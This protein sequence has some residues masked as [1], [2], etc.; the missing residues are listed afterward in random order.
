MPMGAGP[1]NPAP[2]FLEENIQMQMLDCE[3]RIDNEPSQLR[4]F[5]TC[6]LVAVDFPDG[7]TLGDYVRQAERGTFL[8]LTESLTEPDG[9]HV[10]VLRNGQLEFANA[11]ILKTK[12][13][14][15]H[16]AFTSIN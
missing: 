13:L 16:Q 14:A 10:S 4:E 12:L 15:V 7:L 5:K 6:T 2:Y 8:L 9:V 1:K 3:I 11:R